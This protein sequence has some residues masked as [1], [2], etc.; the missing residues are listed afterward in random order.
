ML[1][2]IAVFIDQGRSSPLQFQSYQHKPVLRSDLIQVTGH[3]IDG[4]PPIF[5]GRLK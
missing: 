1:M 2:T 4:N 3:S 5:N